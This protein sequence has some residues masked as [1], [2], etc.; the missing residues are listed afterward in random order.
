VQGATQCVE[1]RRRVVFLKLKR[2]F[3]CHESRIQPP[4]QRSNSELFPTDL[5][6]T[7]DAA[8]VREGF[9]NV[10][11]RNER[12]ADANGVC[13][14]FECATTVTAQRFDDGLIA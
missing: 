9:R 4:A 12:A 7:L 11:C 13:G 10:Q 5:F 1:S 2:R 14:P 8:D 6:G 3:G